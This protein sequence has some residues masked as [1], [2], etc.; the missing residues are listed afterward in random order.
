MAAAAV[1]VVVVVVVVVMEVGGSEGVV[2]VV[3][4]DGCWS[5]G[6]SR[7]QWRFLAFLQ[8]RDA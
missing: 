3:V 4:G 7:Q 5:V 6:S 1:V 8:V 2:S